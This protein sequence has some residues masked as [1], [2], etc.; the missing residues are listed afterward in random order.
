MWCCG[1]SLAAVGGRALVLDQLK[2]GR[3]RARWIRCSGFGES[4]RQ[5]W[6]STG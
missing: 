5:G 1:R 4:G 3:N 6:S 2:L